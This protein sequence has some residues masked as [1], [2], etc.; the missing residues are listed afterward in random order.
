VVV[1]FSVEK[2][3]RN[4]KRKRRARYLAAFPLSL[5]VSLC[6]SV[7]PKG[8]EPP[9]SEPESDI[10]SIELQDQ[11]RKIRVLSLN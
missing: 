8:L 2:R 6:E 11:D 1:I 4:R 3:K 10:L 7:I 5:S 9:S